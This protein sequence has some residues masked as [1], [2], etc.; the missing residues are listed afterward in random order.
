MNKK[1]IKRLFPFIAI[2][3]IILLFSS[4][5]PGTGSEVDPDQASPEPVPEGTPSASDDK[6]EPTQTPAPTTELDP[7]QV[8]EAQYR[9]I[10]NTMTLEEK[11]GQLLVVGYQSD[12]QAEEMIKEHKVGGIVLFSRNFDDFDQL[13]HITKQLNEYNQASP[14]PLWIALDEEGGTVTR[15]P[16]GKT[17][18]PDAR[19]VGSHGDVEL[20][21]TVGWIIGREMAAAGANLDFAPVVDIVDNPE[22]SFMLRRSYGST[23]E[24][25]SEQGT[26]FLKGLQQIGVQGCAKHFPGHGA[27]AVDSHLDMPVI[28]S[29]LEEWLEKDAIPFQAMID[30]GVEMIMVGHLAFPQVDPS[31]LPA[32]MSSV[33]L[34]EQ[35]RNHMGFEGLIITDDIEMQGYPQGADRKEAIITSFLAGIDLFAIGHTPQTQLDVLEALKE[36]VETGR[37]T[38]ERID[39]SLMRIIR[40]KV[41]LEKIPRFSLEEAREIFGSQQHKEALSNLLKN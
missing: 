21:E 35:L 14:L 16:S 4:C 26:A 10:L 28:Y 1:I 22:N 30:A 39:E 5:S 8:E 12:N 27:T 13:Y 17:H 38:Q 11:L 9:E 18:I 41:K 23:P 34:K 7:A 36:G 32:S 29:S 15:L 24:E 40:T 37:I 33:F 6:S 2:M 3:V 31:G 20:T 25:V 19:E